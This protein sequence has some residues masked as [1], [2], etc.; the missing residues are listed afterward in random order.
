MG[1]V[2]SLKFS[3][4]MSG[5]SHR[6]PRQIGKSLHYPDIA[7]RRLPHIVLEKS[8]FI[9]SDKFL[10]GPFEWYVTCSLFMVEQGEESE[11]EVDRCKLTQTQL[12]AVNL[13]AEQSKRSCL[14]RRRSSPPKLELAEK[15][16]S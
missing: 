15:Y 14:Q 10:S 12:L 13:L 4:G 6:F 5:F 7:C 9:R 3:V 16:L 11:N 2:L 8:V 1:F